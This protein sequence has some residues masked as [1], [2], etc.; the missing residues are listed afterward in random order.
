MP[1]F[2][3]LPLKLALDLM[4]LST[5]ALHIEHCAAASIVAANRKMIIRYAAIFFIGL[6]DKRWTTNSNNGF[7]NVDRRV[8]SLNIPQHR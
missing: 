5:V 6:K 3:P 7:V 4:L 8:K 2:K 1:L